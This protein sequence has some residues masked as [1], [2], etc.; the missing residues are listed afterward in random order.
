VGSP[1]EE[2]WEWVWEGEEDSY[3]EV[4]LEVLPVEED[5]EEEEDTMIE[6]DS[7]VGWVSYFL[8]LVRQW[9]E[10]IEFVRWW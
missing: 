5:L 7:K 4:A 2:A 10:L 9:M 3:N 8:F 1:L 6:G